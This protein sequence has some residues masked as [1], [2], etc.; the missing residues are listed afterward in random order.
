MFARLKREAAEARQWAERAEAEAERIRREADEQIR[1][2]ESDAATS[3]KQLRAGARDEMTRL[4]FELAEANRRAERAE[5]RLVRIRQEVEG[6]FCGAFTSP[7][8]AR[9]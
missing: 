8:N 6:L 1:L 3:L 5:Q 7:P 4:Q 2:V 9:A